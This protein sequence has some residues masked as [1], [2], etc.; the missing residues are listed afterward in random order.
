MG[1]RGPGGTCDAPKAT[2]FV[3]AK[4]P[5]AFAPMGSVEFSKLLLREAK[6]ATSPGIGFGE[7]GEGYVR[8]ALIENEHRIRQAVKGIRSVLLSE[9]SM[10]RVGIIGL[11][12]VGRGTY[13]ILEEHRALIARKT[14][15]R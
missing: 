13:R 7:Y 12:T 14:V 3:W 9:K 6:V 10:I 11:G 15:W 2:M 5:E 8:F 4:I 1:S